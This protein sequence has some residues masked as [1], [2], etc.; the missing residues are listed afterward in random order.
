MT[1]MSKI[2]Y[3]NMGVK[4]FVTT[5][6]IQPAAPLA[7]LCSPS[8]SWE[9]KN[10]L[11]LA[12]P[13]MIQFKN[14]FNRVMYF[15]NEM[16]TSNPCSRWLYQNCQ[17]P[18]RVHIWQPS[19]LPLQPRLHLVGQQP[20]DLH[21]ER[22]VVWVPPHLQEGVLWRPSFHPELCHGAPGR[23]RLNIMECSYDLLMHSR[24]YSW[25]W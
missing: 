15:R 18:W 2:I 3:V 22:G 16:W 23:R 7:E 20:Q 24:V 14:Q 11:R 25:Q 17:L 19:H 5:S 12:I 4:S 10:S 21:R 8:I 13:S 9:N 1:Y 6:T